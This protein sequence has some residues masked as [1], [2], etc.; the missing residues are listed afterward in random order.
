MPMQTASLLHTHLWHGF[1]I[2][3]ASILTPSI[4][5]LGVD[6]GENGSFSL[7]F[8]Q[9]EQLKPYPNGK[10]CFVE[11]CLLGCYAVWLL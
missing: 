2:L 4:R 8:L 3:S 5:L 7:I 9:D 10:S 11:L 6:F 1:V